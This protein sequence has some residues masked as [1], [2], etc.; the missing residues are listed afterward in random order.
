MLLD[1]SGSM[2]IIFFVG[3]ESTCNGFYN[4]SLIFWVEANGIYCRTPLGSFSLRVLPGVITSLPIIS[5]QSPRYNPS[6]GYTTA[7]FYLEFSHKSPGTE[8]IQVQPFID[9]TAF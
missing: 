3:D 2:A 7:C 6:E 8:R 5:F 9:V 1:S 4:H